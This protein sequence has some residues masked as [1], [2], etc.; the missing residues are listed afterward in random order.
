[1]SNR[2]TFILFPSWEKV[3]KETTEQF[4]SFSYVQCLGENL[5][6][7][8][9]RRKGILG[10]GEN[11]DQLFFSFCTKTKSPIASIKYPATEENYNKGIDDLL[12]WAEM[13]S[14][15]F[16]DIKDF[17]KIEGGNKNV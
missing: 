1:M 16:T 10:R 8:I 5:Y 15:A 3:E 12:S 6:L 13:F 4:I 17:A 7:Y 11:L 14:R 2:R 9:E